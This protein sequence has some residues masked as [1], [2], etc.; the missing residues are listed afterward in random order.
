MTADVV[1]L[2]EVRI[3]RGLLELAL[4]E[5]VPAEQ[6]RMTLA[7]ACAMDEDDDR[8]NPKIDHDRL[9]A[10]LRHLWALGVV[11]RKDFGLD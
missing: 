9:E 3:V 11:D 4:A 7:L 5:G 2:E 8:P 10:E 6:L 1:N